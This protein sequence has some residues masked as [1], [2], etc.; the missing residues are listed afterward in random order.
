MNNL[1]LDEEENLLAA[2]EPVKYDKDLLYRMLMEKATRKSTDA[3]ELAAVNQEA[4]RQRTGLGLMEAGETI[5][6]ALAG[7]AP[8][9]GSFEP[10]KQGVD[11]RVQD[12]LKQK[13]TERNAEYDRFQAV[14]ELA[15]LQPK[16]TSAG[17]VDLTQYV[18]IEGGKEVPMLRG[19]GGIGLISAVTGKPLADWKWKPMTQYQ[20]LQGDLGQ[21]NLDLRGKKYDLDVERFG[22]N[23]DMKTVDRANK[24]GKAL[25]ESGEPEFE[26]AKTR[27]LSTLARFNQDI[28]GKGRLGSVLPTY[29]NTD[30]GQKLRS[31]IQALI[32]PIR[33]GYYGSALTSTELKN[34]EDM[35]ATGKGYSEEAFKYALNQLIADKE[36]AINSV[37]ARDPDAYKIYEQ[38]RQGMFVKAPAGQQPASAPSTMSV[39]KKKRLEEL[40]AKKAAGTL[41]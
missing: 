10:F 1:T 12:Y 15:D 22:W 17:N 11:Q 18:G 38:Q 35:T 25:T 39:D 41:K 13:Q 2:T 21:R 20:Q 16:P 29:L 34:F 7:A 14:K 31:D 8:T 26:G 32:T 5:G 3:A 28:P 36:S 23:K 30:E 24:I 27:V 40:R 4:A 33:K 37:K 6:R 19:P 9:K